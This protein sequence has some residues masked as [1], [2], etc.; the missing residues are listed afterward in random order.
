MGVVNEEYIRAIERAS[1]S[2]CHSLPIHIVVYTIFAEGLHKQISDLLDMM[3]EEQ[4]AV[5]LTHSQPVL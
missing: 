1:A 5:D 3:L 4:N 2:P